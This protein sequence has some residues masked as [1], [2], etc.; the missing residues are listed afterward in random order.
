MLKIFLE[1][2]FF[3]NTLLTPLATRKYH[4]IQAVPSPPHDPHDPGKWDTTVTH[5]ITVQI[6]IAMKTQ[7]PISSSCFIFV[8]L[9]L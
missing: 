1:L 2:L 6:V 7:N 3:H 8:G 5:K 4:S 9:T